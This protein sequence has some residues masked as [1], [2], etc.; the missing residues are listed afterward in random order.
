L[1]QFRKGLQMYYE[2][3]TQLAGADGAAVQP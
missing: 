3:V 2:V 1:D